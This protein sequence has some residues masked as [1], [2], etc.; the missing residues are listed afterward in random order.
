MRASTRSPR[1]R[2][3][4][5]SLLCLAAASPA[6][7]QSTGEPD[8][9]TTWG[10][11]FTSTQASSGASLY[12]SRCSSCHRSDLG[13]GTGP[14]LTYGM[15][16]S[17]WEGQPL[18]VLVSLI[19]TTMP[20]T[21]PGSL[22]DTQAA[23]IVAHLLQRQGYAAG[24]TTLT[25]SST[26]VYR[27]HRLQPSTWEAPA[28]GNQKSIAIAA[29][30]TG[31]DWTVTRLPSW[32]TSSRAAATGVGTV[33]IIAAPN[34]T[35]ASRTATILIAN[36]PL[37][38][39][40]PSTGTA[41][42]PS[43]PGN[44]QAT[45]SGQ[46]VTFTWGAPAAGAA[47]TR[48]RI[49]AGAS[50][51]SF[52]TELNV[53][54]ITTHP[55]PGVPFGSY[56]ARIRAGNE[57]GFGEPSAAIPVLVA[58]TPPGTPRNP[59]V[60][61]TGTTVRFGWEAPASGST[62]TGYLIEAGLE[63]GRVDIEPIPWS[64][65]TFEAENVP[66]GRYFLRVRAVAGATS[67]AATSDVVADVVPDLAPPGVPTGL[68]PTVTGRMVTLRWSAPTGGASVA[69]Y[70]LEV[71]SS[72]G[73]SNLVP[74]LVVAAEPATFTAGEVPPGDYFVRVRARSA[75]GVLGSPSADVLV[76]VA[77]SR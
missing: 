26:S 24:T 16:G 71:G 25:A 65:T 7:A 62:P 51:D 49:E 37:T 35:G 75:A 54:A 60:T 66:T 48:Y 55:V 44:F 53:G 4:L 50:A 58:A 23:A 42:V 6:L 64:S 43:T 9:Q 12:S 68:A 57:A 20:P 74:G 40:Q 61:V 13:G 1:V 72:S 52:P 15:F 22:S 19:Q 17:H 59:A 21:D 38:V 29:S 76:R 47:P 2:G 3:L 77:G 8:S 69:A 36:R 73:A 56:V 10:G 31:H 5:L 41:A 32:L 30:D 11:I 18:S 39:T 33:T 46:Q 67:G 45:V 34:T 70:I 63:A 14:E 28:A 27:S